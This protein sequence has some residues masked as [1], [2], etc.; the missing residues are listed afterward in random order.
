MAL[1]QDQKERIATLYIEANED[2]VDAENV[3]AHVGYLE[4]WLAAID[5]AALEVVPWG[6][7]Q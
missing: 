4:D 3:E 6:P 2:A 7:Q 5:A 1:T